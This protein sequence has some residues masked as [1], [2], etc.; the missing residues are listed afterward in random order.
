MGYH[1][2]NYSQIEARRG[3][4]GNLLSSFAKVEAHPIQAMPTGYMGSQGRIYNDS[5]VLISLSDWGYNNQNSVSIASYTHANYS[6]RGYYYGRGQTRAYNG[7]G[8]TTYWTFST[9]NIF[10]EGM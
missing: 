4:S 9:P 1:Y 8:Y 10:Y 2:R 5:G 7:N 3:P 6:P